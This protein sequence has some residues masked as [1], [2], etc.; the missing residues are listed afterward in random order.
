L[1]RSDAA[2]FL[3][4]LKIYPFFWYYRYL[5]LLHLPVAAMI[6]K[7]MFSRSQQRMAGRKP[8]VPIHNLYHMMTPNFLIQMIDEEVLT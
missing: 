6:F 7:R 4:L 3:D 5:V 2:N 1:W 8:V